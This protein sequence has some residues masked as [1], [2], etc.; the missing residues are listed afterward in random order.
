MKT[1]FVVFTLLVCLLGQADA[2]TVHSKSGITVH[3]S[4]GARAALQCVVNY[5]EKAGVRI[6]AMRGYGA[7]TVA[8]S[9]HPSGQ[10]LD[11]NQLGRG[12]TSPYVPG[13]VSNAAADKCGVVSGN[14]WANN[15]NGHWNLGHTASRHV[16]TIHVAHHRE[17]T[18]KVAVLYRMVINQKDRFTP[19]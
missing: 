6:K 17:R 10:A 2:A 7:G 13:R 9:L 11:I 15:D 1:I 4:P 18:R 16:R 14:R 3:V 19:L 12:V 8:H 5:V